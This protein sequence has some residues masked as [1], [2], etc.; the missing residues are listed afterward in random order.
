MKRTPTDVTL[1]PEAKTEY[2]ICG[3]TLVG[4]DEA[5]VYVHNKKD[6]HSLPTHLHFSVTG[7][8]LT[9]DQIQLISQWTFIGKNFAKKCLYEYGPADHEYSRARNMARQVVSTYRKEYMKKHDVPPNSL[10]LNL[11]LDRAEIKRA[12]DQIIHKKSPRKKRARK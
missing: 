6:P 1:R 8:D 9:P 12:T 7:P 3:K 11:P 2:V 10:G 4:W 5:V